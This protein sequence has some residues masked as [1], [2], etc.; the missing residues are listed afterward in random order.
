MHE[1]LVSLLEYYSL[2]NITL[3]CDVCKVEY[4]I[5]DFKAACYAESKNHTHCFLMRSNF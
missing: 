1:S 5:A 3:A 4:I 2:T